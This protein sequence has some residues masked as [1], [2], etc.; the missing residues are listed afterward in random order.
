M[1]ATFSPIHAQ[2]LNQP[3]HGTPRTK[4]GK[5]N[6]FAKAP[7]L[8]GKPDL[9]GVWQVEPPAKGEIERLIGRDSLT[10]GLVPGDDL[11]TFSKYFFNVLAD[12]KSEESPLRPEAAEIIRNRPKDAETPDERCLPF[13][14]PRAELIGFPFKIVQAFGVIVIMYEGDNSRRQI[15]TDG[16]NLPVDPN[17]AWLGY[18]VGRWDAETLVVDSTGFT[19]KIWIDTVGH[20]VSES[21]RIQERFHRRDFG[22]MDLQITITDPKMY[23][24]PITFTVT[25]LLIP[26]SDILEYFCAENEKDRSHIKTAN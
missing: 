17:P 2:W 12:F 21:L 10:V 5:P 26:D 20:P 18:S 13:G 14:V 3:T 19:D 24:K 25:Q 11:N 9:S 15:Y 8:A 1:L 6:L 7:R 22:H 16:R 23:I 4:D